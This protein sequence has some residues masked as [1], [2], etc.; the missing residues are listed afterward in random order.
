MVKE[1]SKPIILLVDDS[2]ESH[3]ARKKLKDLGVDFRVQRASGATLP[4]AIIGSTSYCG[5]WGIDFVVTGF[6]RKNNK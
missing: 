6:K 3:L 2:K 1:M 5:S 4:C